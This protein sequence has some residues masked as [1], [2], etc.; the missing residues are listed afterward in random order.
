MSI[1]RTIL[2]RTLSSIYEKSRVLCGVAIGSAL[3]STSV[4]AAEE[5]TE[6]AQATETI[7]VIGS[8]VAGRTE[9]DI[10]VPV[11][12]ISSEQL[13]STGQTEVGRM[14]QATVP[15]FNF[16]SSSVSDGSDALRPA[17]LRGLGPDQTLVLVNGR[18]RHQSALVHINTSVGRG[19][20]R[21]D[22]NA[23]PG[24]A[25]KRI[26]VLRDGA[27]AQYG[28]DAIAGVINLVLKDG[29]DPG[30]VSLS[31]G[32]YSEGDGETYNFSLSKG[33]EFDEGFVSLTY[34]YRDRGNTNRAGLSAQCQYTC[35]DDPNNAGV[36]I[37]T[38]PRE[39][40]F[41]RLNFRVGDSD[42]VQHAV[43]I[44]TGMDIGD[45]E[46]YGFMTWSDRENQSGGFYRRANQDGRNPKLS[47]GEAYYQDGFLPLINTLNDDFSIN[48]GYRHELENEMTLDLSVTKGQNSQE[49][50]ISN[51]LNASWVAA[52]GRT[53]SLRGSSQ[54][55][56][57]AGKLVLD[58]T[59]VNL[60][61]TWASDEIS[62]AWGAEFR[63]DGYQIK[64]G[65]EYSWKDYDGIGQGAL[66]GIQVFPGF[67]PGNAVDE[68]RDVYSLYL[69]AEWDI[70]DDFLLTGALRYDDF[71][72]FGNT[73][74]FKVSGRYNIIDEIVIRGAISTGFR[75]PSMQQQ[76]FNNISTQFAGGKAYQVGTFRNDSQLAKDIGI[77]QLQE[78]QSK[79]YSIGMTFTPSNGLTLTVD[80][81][82]IVIDDRIVISDNIKPGSGSAVFDAALA[83]N[84]VT[85]AQFFIN[86][87]NTKTEGVDVVAIYDTSVGEGDL[88]LSLAFNT[89]TTDVTEQFSPGGLNG[90]KPQDVFGAQG[91]SIIEEWQPKDRI[92]FT[93]NY[94]INDF[95][96]NFS[97]NRFGEYTVMD[98]GKTQTF[99]AEWL[100]DVQGTWHINDNVSV[101]IGANNLFDTVPD[102]NT[103]G[104]SRSGTIMDSNGNLIVQSD[105]VFQY[106]RRSAPFGFNGAYYYAGITYQF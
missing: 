63:R 31:Y 101:N 100:T 60:D 8:R 91:V 2:A 93:T 1:N 37:A 20:S 29:S 13:K 80:Y 56:A 45:D 19:T 53:A 81:Y 17:T 46:L 66:G 26:E 77:P 7:S 88:K 76:Y 104:Q 67:T 6:E 24:S 5:A 9:A 3:L 98:G 70:S 69:D 27:A 39:A 4:F 36:V 15:S 51:S 41:N 64:P 68:T 78:E 83:K 72:D 96:V 50:V 89:T 75:A 97:L 102:T 59:T 42:S 30:S 10:P 94:S 40:T 32:E 99:S 18:R 73:T 25:L 57:S 65:E 21:A 92:N 23:I 87:A 54:T 61:M 79:N 35:S 11:D 55:Q 52:Q 82:K 49:Y 90:I 106:S 74:N 47:D 71:E 103:I 84:G 44:N 14:L 16:S 48:V 58:L 22:L 62:Y 28:S 86:G 43:V 105:G 12:L 34:D 33:F 95:S 85:G 38:D